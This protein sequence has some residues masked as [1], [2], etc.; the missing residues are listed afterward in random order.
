[1]YCDCAVIGANNDRRVDSERADAGDREDHERNATRAALP[2]LELLRQ[3]LRE[4]D[5]CAS[6][7][8]L[9]LRTFTLFSS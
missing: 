1:M 4:H 9:L 5:R 3:L 8:A 7:Y 6:R 2:R